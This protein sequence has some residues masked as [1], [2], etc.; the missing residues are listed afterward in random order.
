M[1][2]LTPAQ[3]VALDELE[4]AYV[5]RYGAAIEFVKAQVGEGDVFAN[6]AARCM[7]SDNG[8]WCECID[9]PM[10]FSGASGAPSA[11]R[12]VDESTATEVLR[13]YHAAR[14]AA[15]ARD[16][17]MYDL[18]ALYARAGVASPEAAYYYHYERSATYSGS[19]AREGGLFRADQMPLFFRCR[20]D[21]A[22]GEPD[23]PLRRGLMFALSG[24]G[25]GVLLVEMDEEGVDVRDLGAEPPNTLPA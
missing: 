16:A 9:L 25:E 3:R 5:R 10:E 12:L 15:A 19:H 7:L 11:Y 14:E 20:V 6:S 24:I 8:A 23:L 22:A 13:R 4:E 18:F 17:R 1:D 2:A 21:L